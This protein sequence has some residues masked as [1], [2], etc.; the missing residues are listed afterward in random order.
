MSDL[1]QPVSGLSPD[2]L[3][4][5]DSIHQQTKEREDADTKQKNYLER[6][7]LTRGFLSG[8]DQTQGLLYGAA[9]LAADAMPEGMPGRQAVKDWG[10]QGYQDN[11]KEAE[12]NP[13]T[14][15]NFTDISTDQGVGQTLSDAGDWFAGNLGR[16]APSMIEGLASAG[17]GAAAGGAATGGLGAV[18]G[19]VAGAAGK[20]G[21]KK[22][23]G[24][25][26]E[27][28]M[29]RQI[30]KGVA[31]DVAE[32]VAA[33]TVGKRIGANVGTTLGVGALE[34]GGNWAGDM[35]KLSKGEIKATD[36]WANVAFGLISGA[37]EIISPQGV[38]ARKLFGAGDEPIKK[39]TQESFDQGVSG[40][41]NFLKRAGREIPKS[42]GGEGLQEITQEFLS[43]MNEMVTDPTVNPVDRENITRM[44]NSG[45]AG[46]AGGVGFGAV[47]AVSPGPVQIVQPGQED[48][49]VAPSAPSAPSAPPAGPL[50]RA[51]AAS[52]VGGVFASQ[53]AMVG[54]DNASAVEGIIND[55]D[56]HQ[57]ARTNVVDP[58]QSMLA[59]QGPGDLSPLQ[60]KA[61]QAYDYNQLFSGVP[62]DIQ[63]PIASVGG[64]DS[65]IVD[66]IGSTA[67]GLPVADINGTVPGGDRLATGETGKDAPRAKEPSAIAI[68]AKGQKL[69]EDEAATIYD[70]SVSEKNKNVRIASLEDGRTAYMVYGKNGEQLSSWKVFPDSGK[71]DISSVKMDG[72]VQLSPKED[73][74]GR[75]VDQEKVASTLSAIKSADA[76]TLEDMAKRMPSFLKDNPEYKEHEQAFRSEFNARRQ[77]L[78]GNSSPTDGGGNAQLSGPLQNEKGISGGV[79]P[80]GSGTGSEAGGNPHVNVGGASGAVGGVPGAVGGVPGRG[81]RVEE[82]AP[83]PVGTWTELAPGDVRGEHRAT[84]ADDSRDDQGSTAVDGEMAEGKPA[85]SVGKP[86]ASVDVAT[87]SQADPLYDR[88]KQ[89]VAETG[90]N[91]LGGLM[92]ALEVDD[93]D[94]VD[95]IKTRLDAEQV[96]PKPE[97]TA[98]QENE[99]APLSFE[100][101]MRGVTSFSPR[102]ANTGIVRHPG[103]TPRQFLERR[104]AEQPMRQDAP[105]TVKNGAMVK[106]P[107]ETLRSFIA[108][109]K[110]EAASGKVKEPWEMTRKEYVEQ[111]SSEYKERTGITATETGE[112]IVR[113]H[114]K[115]AVKRALSE[116]KPVPPEVLAEYPD[117]A[118]K[119]GRDRRVSPNPNNEPQAY[120][121]PT[122]EIQTRTDSFTNRIANVADQ[123]SNQD[124][125]VDK[126]RDKIADK[127]ASEKSADS[128]LPSAEEIYAT[129]PTPLPKNK[130]GDL[131]AVSAYDEAYKEW[132]TAYK[133]AV[134]REPND[135]P[136]VGAETELAQDEARQATDAPTVKESLTVQPA[137]KQIHDFSNT[138]VDITGE[139][140]RKIVEFGQQ[141]PNSE[142]YTDPND[143]SYGREENPHVT[144]RYGLATDNPK[145]VAGLSALSAI[146]AKMGKVSIFETDKYDVVKVEIISPALRAANKKV[147]ELVDLPGETFKDYQPHATIAYVKK[148]EGQKYAGDST[149]EGESVS[150]DVINL[151]DRNGVTHPIKLQPKTSTQGENNG[152]EERQGRQGLL[153]ETTQQEPSTVEGEET[154]PSADKFSGNKVFTADK[155]AS[156]RER[157]KAKR[158]SLSSGFDPE[159]MQDMLIIGGAHFEAGVRKFS[160]WSKAV[161]ADIGEEFKPF[162]RGTYENLRHYPGIEKDGMSTADEIDGIDVDTIGKEADNPGK[163]QS[164]PAAETKNEA[165]DV[166]ANSQSVPEAKQSGRTEPAPDRG[167]GSGVSADAGAE[168]SGP[169]RPNRQTD[170]R[171]PARRSDRTSEGAQ[172]GADDRQRS[173]DERH[174]GISEQPVASQQNYRITEADR[175]GKG[176][177]KQ[178][179]RGNIKAIRII[180]QLRQESRLA[181]AAEQAQLVKYVGWGSSELANG[182]FPQR[183]YDPTSRSMVDRYKDDWKTIGEELRA[184]LTDEEYNAAKASTI[185]A[186]YTSE[187]IIKGMYAALE[188]FG[189]T[190]N[191]KALEPGSGVGHF[192]GLLPD[193]FTAGTRFTTVEMDPISAGIA[194]ALYPGHDV[195]QADFTKFKAP[196][197][198]FDLAIGNPPFADIEI[199]SDHDYAEKK[200]KLHDYFFAKSIDKV[201]PGGLMVLVTSRY[202]MDKGNDKARSYLAKRADLL[203]AIRL[204]QTAFKENAGTEVV[205]DVLF[206]RKR[207]EGERPAG[208]AW[209]RLEP[210]QAG[211]REI[212][213]NEYFSAHPE[214]VLGK[215]STAGSMYGPGQYTVE[216]N[217]GDIAEQFAQAVANL[218]ENVYQA[219]K[220]APAPTDSQTIE[221]EWSPQSVKEGAF[222]LNSKGD[223]LQKENGMG[224]PVVGVGKKKAVIKDF[225][226]IRD[227]VRQVLY[228]QLKDEGDLAAA[229]QELGDAYDAFV[230]AHGPINKTTEVASTNK[231]TGKESISYRYPNFSHF[232]ADPDAYLVA[233]IEKYD[234]ATHKAA[235][236][237]IF[238]KRVISPPAE[239]RVESLVDALHV[240]LHQAGEVDVPLIAQMMGVDEDT[241]IEGLSGAIYLDPNGNRWVTADEY[242]SGNVRRKLAAARAAADIEPK[243]TANVAALEAVQPQDLPPSRIKVSLGMPI[244]QAEQ[245]ESFA[246]E[247]MQMGIAV[248]HIAT[249]GTWDVTKRSGWQT[250]VATNDYGT[251]RLDAADLIDA[252]L[253]NRT[254]KVYDRDSDGKQVF[255]RDATEAAFAKLQKIRERFSQWAWEDAGRSTLLARKFNDLYNNTV[256]R[257]YGGDHIKQMR[258][259]GMSAVIT[260]HEH[261]K[262]VAWR[263]V[264]RGNTYMAHSVG[265][266]K[267][268]GSIIAGME[269]KRLGIKKKPMWVVPNHMLKQ[270]SSEFQQLYP[271]AKL[272]VADEEQFAKGNR[273]RFMGRIAAE[274]WDG[275]IITHSA[276]GKIPVSE[277][278]QSEFIGEQI[279]ELEDMMADA[280]GDRTKTK[281]LER[282]KKRLEQRLERILNNA[283]KDKGVSFEESGIDQLFVD[284][285]HQ[286]RKLDFVTNQTSISGIDPNGSLMAFDLYVKTRY[287]ETMYPGRSMVMMSGTP[288]T[289]TIGEVYTIQR[290]LSESA[291]RE[292]DI[293]NF[294]AWAATFGESVTELV[295]TPAGTYQPKT[296]FG[297]FR[298]M[299]SLAGMW[300]EIGDFVHAK[301]LPYLKRPM[302]DGGARKM[303]IGQ[304]SDIQKAYKQSLAA[305][306]KAIKERKGPPQ[307]GDDILLTVITD[308]RH[309]ALDE[310][311]IAPEAKA[312]KDAKLEMLVDKV[313]GIWTES[314]EKRST[315]MIFADLGLPQAESTRGFSVYKHIKQ[316]LMRRGVPEAEIAFMQDYKKSDEKQKLFKAMNNGDVRVLIGSSAAMGTGV[317]AQRKLVALHHFDPDTYLPSNIEQ[318][319][320]RIVRQGNENEQ[321][322]LYV[323]LTRGSYDETMWQF[324]E[325]KQ[326]FIDQFLAGSV[327]EDTVED[328]DGAANQYAEARAMSSDNPLVLELAGLENDISKLESLRR[329]HV[330]GQV[331]MARD[332][333]AWEARIGTIEKL[334]P[335]V[336]AAA[337]ARVDTKGE[338]FS[339]TISG[340][341][342]KSRADAGEKLIGLLKSQAARPVIVDIHDIGEIAGFTLKARSNMLDPRDMVFTLWHGKTELQGKVEDRY[343]KVAIENGLEKEPSPAGLVMRLENLA[344]G[345]DERI[346]ALKAEL[347][348]AEHVVKEADNRLGAKFEQLDALEDKRARAD[349]I[350]AQLAREGSEDQGATGQG[351]Q[352]VKLSKSISS[353]ELTTTTNSTPSDIRAEVTTKLGRFRT[354]QLLRKG[355]LNIVGSQEDIESGA[356]PFYSQGG[357]IQGYTKSGKVTLVADGIKAGEGWQVFLHEIT[358]LTRLGLNQSQFNQLLNTIE[359]HRGKDSVLGKAISAAEARIPEDTNPEYRSEEILSYLI[360]N[361]KTDVGIVRRFIAMVKAALVKMG[362]SPN[363]FKAEDFKALAVNASK[364]QSTMSTG[365][366]AMQSVREKFDAGNNDVKLSVA[367]NKTG[368]ISLENLESTAKDMAGEIKKGSITYKSN[369]K[370]DSTFLDRLFSTPEYYFKKTSEAAGRVLQAALLR[371]D[372]RFEKQREILNGYTVDADGKRIANPEGFVQFVQKLRKANRAAYDE[373]NTYLVELDQDGGGFKIKPKDELWTVVGPDKKIVSEHETEDEAVGAMILAEGKA[374]AEDGYSD[375]SIEAV[376]MARDLTN[377]AFDVMAA[378]MRRIIAEAEAN[379]RPN[380]FIGSDKIDEAGRYGVYAAGSKQPLAVFSS[381]REA[382]EMLGRISEMVSYS[383]VSAKGN[384]KEFNS[385]LKARAWAAKRGGKVEGTKRFANLT[386]KKRTDAEMRPMTVK[387]ALAEM[388]DLRGSY[389]PRIRERGEYVLKARK[390]GEN[391]FRQSFDLPGVGDGNLLQGVLNSVTPIGRKAKE[392]KAKGYTVT[393]ERDTQPTDD[394]FDATSLITSLD[395]ILQESMAG[396]NK[397]DSGEVKAAQVVDQILTMQIADIFKSRGYLASRMKRLSGDETWEGYETDMGKALTQYGKNIAAGTA[398]RDTARAMV[399]AFTG[400]DYSWNDYKAE[401]ENPSWEEYKQ[402]VD[403]RRIDPGKQKN[404]FK[405]VRAFIVDVL[406]NDEQVDRIIGTMKGLAVHKFLGL[407]VSSAAINATNMVTGVVGTMAGHTGE[408]VSKSLGRVFNAAVA[409]G[410]YRTK[411]RS[412]SAEDRSIFLEIT[413]R[414][415][416]EAQFDHEAMSELRSKVGDAWNKYEAVSM[417]MFSAVEK[418]NRAMTIFAALKAVEAKHPTMEREAQWQ[419]AQEI[420]NKAHGVYGKE[421]LPAMARGGDMNRLLRLPLTFTKFTHNYMLNMI[422]T[423]FNKKELGAAAYLLLSPAII[424]GSGA[425]L[426]TPAVLALAGALGIG[427]DDPEEAWYK[428]AE[429]TFGGGT[430]ARHGLA[431]LAGINIKGSMAINVPMPADIAKIKMVDIFGPVGGVAG[432]VAKGVGSLAKGDVAKG[433]E[434]L[435]PTALGSM[436][437]SIREYSEGV[438]TS[439]YGAVF[440]GDEPLKATDMDAM[441]RFLSFNPSRISGIREMQ[442]NEKEV[443][444]K[445]QER[446]NEIN[447]AIKRDHLQ[448]KQISPENLKS[449]KRYNDLVDGSGRGDISK[450]TPKSIRLMLKR[451]DKPTKV[452]KLRSKELAQNPF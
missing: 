311:F 370:K 293:H 42:M 213:V 222:Y 45:A 47:G 79:F 314:A 253:N 190:G 144:V 359:R 54:A 148:G 446:R 296:R 289:N 166:Q 24:E 19:A 342:Y 406:R 376:K 60:R 136:G 383:V 271:A 418:A 350:R 295:A 68:R 387:E 274:N 411:S 39:M 429:H 246:A 49:L 324:I 416:D 300:G 96:T 395:A 216:P 48:G 36:P 433:V 116:N 31:A 235:K 27:K 305:R 46:A 261:Q 59:A 335:T 424:A 99:D 84:A 143:D 208:K 110:S 70:V 210:V 129:K 69:T 94:R 64:Q 287:L 221:A 268:I 18:P 448:G 318:R 362:I 259:P 81:G 440:Y 404:M 269:L 86:A 248:R 58:A 141:I 344:R 114:H 205:T 298:N 180:K 88:A 123:Q 417:F 140:A 434:S 14:V 358:H 321:V 8:V 78:S 137:Q 452:E 33:K 3:S 35:E 405:D 402:I 1:T 13:L 179:A 444:S 384:V 306:I 40:I 101:R 115:D 20:T 276:F 273:N 156:A 260:P 352:E 240:S 443:A 189:Y 381:E 186:H 182:V 280:D 118:A 112:N 29:G 65:T 303:I 233:A 124:V 7:E 355:V 161:L 415:W 224:A 329:A 223:L 91:T 369:T 389:F 202:T 162:L 375:A 252:A 131:A 447:S 106:A 392:L 450:I 57:P 6:N 290:F 23:M 441:L 38:L 153:N 340:K 4:E 336:E 22:V 219:D 75:K 201:R 385:M 445:Y 353:T 360:E 282:Q 72:D 243:Y 87:D 365:G 198:F 102:E 312:R 61:E 16:L 275:I 333:S 183:G 28:E 44:L 396:V 451:S 237:D 169:G 197:N 428:W 267:T 12:L 379:G 442:W 151:T 326:R 294:D 217:K 270:F 154:P 236:T 345:I 322:Q 119:V 339:M 332:R 390:D 17:I 388:G 167:E 425:T 319:E 288:V 285:A 117:I 206:L 171:K 391:P 225:V 304:S 220:S 262:R 126:T 380:P 82:S 449:I 122:G 437:K 145:D 30:A 373:A 113:S 152:E 408:S 9:G 281:Q 393:I 32:S 254:V 438:T 250:L 301:D 394:V 364:W 209:G 185:N 420:S 52:P 371:R 10:Y 71:N 149:F 374:M 317:N 286:F 401:V 264:Q 323:Y 194:K 258:F 187:K 361:D 97:N 67:A 77:E 5:L 427:G 26:I 133:D 103:E 265:A 413:N 128:D 278:Y 277:E 249:T 422:D 34:G 409:Y 218:P 338:L 168:L 315:Q 173:V 272:L 348:K 193:A 439:N 147:G 419:M 347:A 407:R 330:D 397:N 242:L 134:K 163:D 239:P 120:L 308:G 331:R 302:I 436:S 174:G 130:R 121:S 56:T 25:M 85:A 83:E 382:A 357:L 310:R 157:L 256:K 63:Q 73:D 104:K 98:S 328:I 127:S 435:L 426:A 132:R 291:L 367:A 245:V 108:R 255:N 354:M 366:N 160:A 227:A 214:M 212:H 41:K 341:D 346:E 203:G 164:P 228:V 177:A 66:P 313:H 349:E 55:Y 414:G 234:D 176:G 215:H 356:E 15:E 386:V 292:L 368:P 431:G 21:V 105:G 175:L 159:L 142:I 283:S 95:A 50:S 229:Q 188:R 399:L 181:T 93:I 146:D 204:P 238:T 400:R 230:A 92:K 430:F 363:I 43:I 200:F 337:K 325:S 231:T 421:T 299:P 199:V 150:F 74:T 138:Q 191:G 232:K 172:H 90:D 423:G 244:I 432:D 195:R 89:H 334:L 165:T 125:I 403:E 139:P 109:Q 155:V 372:V 398:K 196:D 211:D 279:A 257:E 412:L 410:Q 207:L 100:E 80:G 76:D 247:V 297:R 135:L 263:I 158:G 53:P 37:T 309:A 184:A 251:N 11:Q 226:R 351:E 51:V 307:K 320:G 316:E 343:N 62:E 241:A 170:D 266:G 377:R 107:G 327:T 111:D 178:K 192:I 378:D 284:E 2:L